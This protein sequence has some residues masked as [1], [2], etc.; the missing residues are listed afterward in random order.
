MKTIQRFIR[1]S[2]RKLRL[3]ADAVRSLSP[4][5]AL[6]HLKFTGKAAADPMYKAIKQAVSNAKE[7]AGLAVSSLAFKTIDVMEGPTYKRFQAVSRGM[8][9]SIM[10]RT[11]H[12]RIE[13]KEVNHGSKS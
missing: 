2:P 12:I 3:V 6:L 11:S 1:T 10:K 4:E 8:A 9:H 5:Q 7:Q 13:L